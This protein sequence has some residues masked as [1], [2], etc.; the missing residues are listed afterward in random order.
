MTIIKIFLHSSHFD[1]T[2]NN[3]KKGIVRII[4]PLKKFLVAV[5]MNISTFFTGWL[6]M[7]DSDLTKKARNT[8]ILI[9]VDNIVIFMRLIRALAPFHSRQ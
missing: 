6:L 3:E 1:L 2:V 9:C 8:T 4:F 7:C 5:P